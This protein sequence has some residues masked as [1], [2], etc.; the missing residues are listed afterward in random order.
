[1]TQANLFK[2]RKVVVKLHYSMIN[3]FAFLWVKNDRPCNFEVI[4]SKKDPEFVGVR[5]LVENSETTDLI[6]DVRNNLRAEIM[7]V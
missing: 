7:Y 1:M 5:F 3:Q 4:R 2:P 6:A